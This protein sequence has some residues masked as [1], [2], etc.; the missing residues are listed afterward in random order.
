MRAVLRPRSVV[1][2]TFAIIALS[3]TGLGQVKDQSSSSGLQFTQPPT[4]ESADAHSMTV[5]W[6][7]NMSGSTVVRYGTDQNNLNQIFEKAADGKTHRA[8]I[9]DQ[10][11]PNT[12]YYFVAET[13]NGQGAPLDSQVF[14]M[15]TPAAGTLRDVKPT[16]VGTYSAPSTSSPGR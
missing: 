12:T 16:S 1:V 13:S 8:S 4:V 3:L 10:L 14:S 11:Q 15:K 6:K 2:M 7:T 9:Q 5:M